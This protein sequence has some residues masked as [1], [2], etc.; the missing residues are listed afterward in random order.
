MRLA[1]ARNGLRRPV[2]VLEGNHDVMGGA[3]PWFDSLKGRQKSA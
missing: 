1:N 2:Q 3:C